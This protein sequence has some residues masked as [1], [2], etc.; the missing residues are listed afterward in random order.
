MSG[1]AV[2][3]FRREF[4]LML[5]HFYMLSVTTGF[6]WIVL[7]CLSVLNSKDMP[8]DKITAARSTSVSN[9]DNAEFATGLMIGKHRSFCIFCFEIHLL[10]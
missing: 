8:G 1:Q 10:A 6:S 3:C 2:V 9:R 5:L 4:F 7:F